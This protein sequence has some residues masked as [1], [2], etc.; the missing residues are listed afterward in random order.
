MRSD[1][2]TTRFRRALL[3]TAAAV[4]PFGALALDAPADA[5]QPSGVVV[6]RPAVVLSAPSPGRAGTLVLTGDRTLEIGQTLA[7]SV[8]PHTPH[9]F[10]GKVRS[11]SHAHGRTLVRTQP[12][13]LRTAMPRGSLQLA[14]NV[15]PARVLRRS[16][17]KSLACPGGGSLAVQGSLALSATPTFRLAWAPGG[18]RSAS[19]A[20]ALA[21]RLD[22]RTSV[23]SASSCTLP[24]R[25]LLA[26]PVTLGRFVAP[27]NGVPVV[28][29]LDGQ[30]FL[31]GRAAASSRATVGVSGTFASGGSVAY[32]MRRLAAG[33]LPA[34]LAFAASAPSFGGPATARL[35]V[36]SEVRLRIYGV[37]GP[38]LSTV[39]GHDFA[40]DPSRRTAWTLTAPLVTRGRL[41]V[42]GIGLSTPTRVLSRRTFTIA[43]A[44]DDTALTRGDRT[45]ADISGTVIDRHPDDVANGDLAF[46]RF[47]TA[48]GHPVDVLRTLPSDLSPYRCVMLVANLPAFDAAATTRLRDYVHSGGT[49]IAVGEWGPYDEG[50]DATMNALASALGVGLTLNAHTI[51]GGPEVTTAIKASPLTAGVASLAYSG[52]SGIAVGGAAQVLAETNGSV[53]GVE[54]FVAAQNLGSGRFAM[55]GDSNVLSDDSFNGFSS[56]GNGTLARNLCG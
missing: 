54:P 19:F 50:A 44:G 16:L 40:G 24:R 36:T 20:A 48:T 52:T 15:L 43:R 31:D 53:G 45:L 34:R 33:A 7:A 14:K 29:E 39:T 27:V 3:L 10:F 4:G 23:T 42:P 51:G 41:A 47:A 8:G 28:L 46:T 9:G 30:L 35:H 6:L 18:H 17:A 55:L 12:T 21:G 1:L 38:Q 37:V 56:Q 22:L 5:A 2:S 13:N 32:R 11:I 26:R 49:L 25:P